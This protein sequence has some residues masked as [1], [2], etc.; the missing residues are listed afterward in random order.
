MLGFYRKDDAWDPEMFLT[1]ISAVLSKYPKWVID[2][3]THPA[4]GLPGR[5][6][7]PPQPSEVRDA[8][9]AE[10]EPVRRQAEREHR[11]R[12]CQESLPPPVDRTG[13]KT[14]EQIQA[15]FAAVGIF[16]GGARALPKETAA[17]VKAKLGLTDEQWNAIPDRTNR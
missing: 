2:K 8:C 3:V 17:T 7:F 6:K 13:R 15:E 12:A 16:I 1:G 9:E 4:D 14:Y 5:L 10:M 11:E